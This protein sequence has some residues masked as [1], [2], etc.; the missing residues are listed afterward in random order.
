LLVVVTGIQK[1]K[2][3]GHRSHLVLEPNGFTRWISNSEHYYVTYL[4]RVLTYKF[5]TIQIPAPSPVLS[6][7]LFEEPKD[8]P[9][10]KPKT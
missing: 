2:T 5:L 6:P 1:Y 7:P 8:N 3:H 9:K 10:K 4:C